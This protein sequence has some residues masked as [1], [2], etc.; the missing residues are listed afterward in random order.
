MTKCPFSQKLGFKKISRK[1]FQEQTQNF[2][3]QC[4]ENRLEE[5]F[6]FNQTLNQP[7]TQ[8]DN[9]KLLRMYVGE[10]LME[11]YQNSHLFPF[12]ESQCYKSQEQ[13]FLSQLRTT[14]NP[15]KS[16]KAFQSTIYQIPHNQFK[17]QI[18]S[19]PN[20]ELALCQNLMNELRLKSGWTRG[21]DSVEMINKDNLYDMFHPLV[22]ISNLTEENFE[23]ISQNSL[24]QM[25]QNL[26]THGN[27]STV[28]N[29]KLNLLRQRAHEDF[30][31]TYNKKENKIEIHQTIFKRFQW[32]LDNL[33]KKELGHASKNQHGCP[34]LFVTDKKI[35]KPMSYGYLK[36][37]FMFFSKVYLE[38]NKIK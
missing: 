22:N 29:K 1:Q 35:N 20:S 7:K 33:T 17:Q 18:K 12:L 9:D 2:D 27:I 13:D 4:L 3:N 37:K 30:G 25:I 36:N 26:H 19:N 10:K 32:F 31:Y 21:I 34:I 5:L 38:L 6:L 8:S 14:I 24:P 28:I 11:T 15:Y 23:T 16:A